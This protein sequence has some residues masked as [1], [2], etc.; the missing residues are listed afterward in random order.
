MAARDFNN[1]RKDG[2]ELG[3]GHTVTVLYEVVPV[4]V[5]YRDGDR[6]DGRPAVD[7][8]KYQPQAQERPDTRIAGRGGSATSRDWLTVKARYKEPEGDVSS[9]IEQTVRPGG[10]LR[11]LPFMSAVAEF[12]I[13]MRDGDR[14]GDRWSSVSRRLSNADVPMRF[15]SDKASLLELVDIARGLS[16]LHR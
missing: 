4:G 7:P 3:A 9:L 15:A 16:R 6:V 14:N 12:A 5:V 1:D 11:Y 10:R 8:L 2:G 13:L